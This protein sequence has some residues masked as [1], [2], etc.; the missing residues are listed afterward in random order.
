MLH[1]QCA[2]CAKCMKTHVKCISCNDCDKTLKLSACLI[3]SKQTLIMLTD[4]KNEGLA[5]I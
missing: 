2:Q 5:N 3:V 1:K 4:S